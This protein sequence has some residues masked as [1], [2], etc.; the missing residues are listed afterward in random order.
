[1]MMKIYKLYTRGKSIRRMGNTGQP[2]F[3]DCVL[4]F[5]ITKWSHLGQ[6]CEK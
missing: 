2:D 3:T 1:M 6:L 5:T 4:Y